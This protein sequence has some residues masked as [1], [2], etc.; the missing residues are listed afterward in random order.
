MTASEHRVMIMAGGTGGHVY[1]GLAVAAALRTRGWDVSWIGTAR[2]LEARVIPAH[3]IT[4]HTLT[5]LGLRGKG[6]ASKLKGIASLLWSCFQAL[7]L[8]LRHRPS[9]VIGFGGYAA[10]PAG[11]V[12]KLLGIP[13][14]IHEQ[15]AVAGT[16]N[17]LLARRSTRVMAGFDGAFTTDV[18]VTV[19]GNPLR[20]ELC[21]VAEKVYP[22]ASFDTSRR[23]RIAILGGSQGALALNQGCPQA[24]SRLSAD[25]LACIDIKHQCGLAHVE[26]TEASW[27]R[28]GV[29]QYEVVPFVE[30]MAALYRWADLAIC[31]AGAL[32][33]SEAAVTGTPSLLVPLPQ[34]IDNHQMRNAEAL[35]SAGGASIVPQSEMG[36]DAI[37]DFLT[38]ILTDAPTLKQMSDAARAWSKPNATQD[39]VAIAEEV[40]CG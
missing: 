7:A 36:S 26:V 4:L 6:V 11:A 38:Q 21:D 1:P 9:M 31:R 39:V 8:L 35:M 12:A 24:L 30:D 29:N 13:L 28:V 40:A 27:G 15:N 16:T 33:V 3:H 19:T 2:G 10:G 37:P 32:T 23:L 17:R 18:D 34:A 5:T 22:A 20:D 14:L 25:E